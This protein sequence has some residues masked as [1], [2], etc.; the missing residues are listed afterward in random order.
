MYLFY[1][2]F[3]KKK[4]KYAIYRPCC[5]FLNGKPNFECHCRLKCNKKKSY[6]YY[7]KIVRNGS[8]SIQ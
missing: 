8:D 5:I 1:A 7:N 2:I 6:Y 4:W 3:I